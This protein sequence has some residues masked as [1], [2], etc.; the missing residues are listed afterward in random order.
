[1]DR[2]YHRKAAP[3]EAQKTIRREFPTVWLR[4]RHGAPATQSGPY[5]P[6]LLASERCRE[7]YWVAYCA[8]AAAVVGALR[9]TKD[10]SV[11]VLHAK[12][13]S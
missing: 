5:R 4:I 11:L 6:D 2:T 1:M 13:L 3:R 8:L 9:G 10:S 12:V 7:T